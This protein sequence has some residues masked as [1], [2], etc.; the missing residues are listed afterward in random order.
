MKN[1]FLSPVLGLLF[2][3]VAGQVAHAQQQSPSPTHIIPCLE[4]Q[5]YKAKANKD[6]HYQQSVTQT[7]EWAKAK[8][9][10]RADDDTTIY[11][12]P[13]VVHI[14][15]NTSQENISDAVVQAQIDKLNEDYRRLNADA[16]TTR[17]I[18]QPVATDTRIEFYLATE[19]PDGN[20]STGITRT[21]TDQTDFSP[22]AG[23][24]PLQI[25]NDLLACGLTF[26][27]IMGLF[28]G[29]NV[30][31]TPDQEACAM[32]VL[33][34]LLSGGGAMDAMK[35]DDQGGKSAWDT[36]RYLNIWV[37]DINGDNPTL[38]LVLGFAYPPEG[39]PNWPAG[40][41][42]TPET[43]GVVIDYHA[44]GGTTNPN[45][46]ML[47]PFADEGRSCVHE[48]GHYLGLRHIWGDADCTE[49]D[50]IADTPDADAASDASTGCDWTKNTCTES[51]GTQLP[52]MIENY[53]DYSSD[54]CQNMFTL[55]Q[56]GIMRSM[57]QGPRSGLLWQNPAL[58]VPAVGSP[59][60]AKLLV[61]RPNPANDGQFA[62]VLSPQ[63]QGTADIAI[64]NA[65]GQ[66]VFALQTSEKQIPIDA[67]Q[68]QNGIYIAKVNGKNQTAVEKIVIK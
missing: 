50:G 24:D 48:V 22:L 8:A 5:I 33:E 17:A 12:I 59:N 4:H 36:N 16:A 32:A 34:P 68:W 18:F 54:D 61:A 52:D 1:L 49:D 11:H 10:Q 66:Q 20:P 19:D 7:Y 3:A 27:Q 41:T 44:F 64:F 26:D 35:F 51:T 67:A 14:V 46:S 63:M 37:C 30:D 62:L 43:D 56:A 60:N 6:N 31:L 65:A 2:W 25:F 47:A 21:Q 23:I 13:V 45:V 38:G 28:S 39:A 15:F 53:M 58:G 9:A 29:A 42:G 55:D 40:S 57:L